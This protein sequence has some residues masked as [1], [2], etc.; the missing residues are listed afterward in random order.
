MEAS[1]PPHI[2]VGGVTEDDKME[3]IDD[4]YPSD[5]EDLM[6]RTENMPSEDQSI[7]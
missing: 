1:T 2:P 3:T 7:H 6:V 5:P 4:N